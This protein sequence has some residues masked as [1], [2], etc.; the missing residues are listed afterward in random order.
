MR[1]LPKEKFVIHCKETKWYMVEIEAD[2][3]DQAVK[4]LKKTANSGD[5]TTMHNEM[6]TTSVSQEV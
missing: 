3:Y 4:Q 1:K 5:Y 6:E 2:N